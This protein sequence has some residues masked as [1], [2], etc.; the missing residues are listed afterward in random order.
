MMMDSAM[1][2]ATSGDAKVDATQLHQ[3]QMQERDQMV[4]MIKTID[5]ETLK[6]MIMPNNKA[7]NDSLQSKCGTEYGRDMYR[8]V[9]MHHREGIQMIDRFLARLQNTNVRSMAEKMRADQTRE[10]AELE[11]KAGR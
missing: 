8:Q 6:P 5:S 1:Q 11:K 10:I 7:V 4:G 3:K 9:I 2:R